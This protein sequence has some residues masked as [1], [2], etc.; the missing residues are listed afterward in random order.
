MGYAERRRHHRAET[1]LGV[2]I[3]ASG[4]TLRG[5][6]IDLSRGGV[7]IR[8]ADDDAACPAVGSAALVELEFG[9]RGWI[10]QDGRIVRC[11]F[12][13]LAIAFDAV[14]DQVA[15]AIDEELRTVLATA[16]RPRLLVVDPS[17]DRRH[18]I[19]EK[20]RAAGCEPYEAATPLEA[21]DLIERPSNHITGVAVATQLTQ[22]DADELCEFVAETNP[23]IRLALI[24]EALAAEP[25]H[26]RITDNLP[27]VDPTSDDTLE[28]SLRG[29][30]DAVHTPPP[31]RR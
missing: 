28:R 29:F 10:A 1:E 13:D 19:A 2:R 25:R 27:A 5:R 14:A 21:I 31:S 17:A 8:R 18:H 12:S 23:G 26:H 7:R 15:R 11:D 24:S 6:S 30:V 9:P 4:S 3:H 16:S 20:L 22:T